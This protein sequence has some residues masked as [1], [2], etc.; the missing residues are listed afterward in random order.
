MSVHINGRK[1]KV[2]LVYRYLTWGNPLDSLPLAGKTPCRVS[3]TSGG[4]AGRQA[5]SEGQGEDKQAD[6]RAAALCP[7]S[8]PFFPFLYCEAQS[9]GR[10][11]CCLL[12]LIPIHPPPADDALSLKLELKRNHPK[13]S[14]PP[15]LH[16]SNG[17]ATASLERSCK[18][19]SR[20]CS[21]VGPRS[22]IV[23][24]REAALSQ[25]RGGIPHTPTAL[26]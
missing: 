11:I 6:E 16:L 12:P 9:Q 21:T 13:P 25:L 4:V 10:G 14:D 19:W 15:H 8:M 18:D 23:F 22:S 2:Y 26:S 17:F 3:I 24:C 20:G 1:T 7:L 5:S